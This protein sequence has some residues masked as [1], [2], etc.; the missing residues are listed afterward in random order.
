MIPIFRCSYRY[1]IL[2]ACIYGYQT[3]GMTASTTTCLCA[4]TTVLLL[5]V[6][7]PPYRIPWRHD[8]T[9]G[10]LTMTITVTTAIPTTRHRETTTPQRL[11]SLRVTVRYKAL[12]SVFSCGV[13]SWGM[14]SHNSP[15]PSKPC[16]DGDHD[17]RAANEFHDVSYSGYRLATCFI[18]F[19]CV[20]VGN[21]GKKI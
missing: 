18:W 5:L 1:S 7:V 6:V 4:F 8:I 17:V 9:T 12:M 19:Q 15:L 13:W 21:S 11:Q 14:M 20:E 2:F 3:M 10:T 16:D